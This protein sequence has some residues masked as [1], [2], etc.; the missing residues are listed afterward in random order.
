MV[1]S[2]ALMESH[3]LHVYHAYTRYA[4]S[5]A[6]T[7]RSSARRR[8]I[9]GSTTLLRM[10]AK[11]EGREGDDQERRERARATLYISSRQI[12]TPTPMNNDR[13]R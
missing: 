2:I 1:R 12:Y 10:M 9:N 11:E 13:R 8:V 5:N 3:F 7:S 6:R 4:S